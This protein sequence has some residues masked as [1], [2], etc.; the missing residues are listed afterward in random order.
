[1]GETIWVLAIYWIDPQPGLFLLLFHYVY[2]LL[3]TDSLLEHNPDLEARFGLAVGKFH[4]EHH[5]IPYVNYG[6]TIDVWDRVF[7]TYSP[8]FGNSYVSDPTKAKAK[9]KKGG[10]KNSYV[11]EPAK[12]KEKI[13]GGIK[14][15][16]KSAK[17]KENASKALKQA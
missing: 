5:R 4:L 2:E 13:K 8:S 7:G 11:S 9:I 17:R 10:G 14:T 15:L 16:S 6:F 1:V 3:A 12:E